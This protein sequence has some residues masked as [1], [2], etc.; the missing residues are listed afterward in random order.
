MT[1]SPE[2]D[3]PADS[4]VGSRTARG[5]TATF[6]AALALQ[7]AIGPFATDMYTPAFPQVTQDLATTS[8]LIGLTITTFFIG[9]GSGQVI[10]GGVSDQVGRR[11]PILAG[12]TVAVLG[13]L[14]C[15]IAPNIWVLLA[16]RFLQGFGGGAAAAVGRAILTDVARGN[17]LARTMSLLQAIGGLAPMLAPVL[18]AL[19]IEHFPWRVVFWTLAGGSALMVVSA[20][21]WTWESLPA[22]QRGQR[23]GLVEFVS[24]LGHVLRERT[25]VSLMFTSAFSFFCL[26]AYISNSSY[27]FQE[28]LGL[29]ARAYSFIFA[30][31]ALLS[32]LGA[33]VNIRLVGR[34]QPRTL[35]L[36]GLTVSMAAVVL[37]VVSV[38]A[39][40]TPLIAVAVGFALLMAAQSFVFGNA[41]ALALGS[42]R[43]WAGTASAIQGLVQAL[44]A[45]VSSPL[46]T[47]GGADPAPMTWVMVAGICLACVAFAFLPR[48][49][50]PSGS[51]LP[52][53]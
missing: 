43:E 26:F 42:V 3:A 28:T 51:R 29:S 20:W 17:T 40:G 13:S 10:G 35:I 5:V 52:T 24:G 8:A 25:F 49:S 14:V 38:F 37:L 15:A 45:A 27:V 39:L 30:G 46:A 19:I 41:A 18:G 44:A 23:G 6:L 32:T 31:N 48:Q 9:F 16:G 7:N 21:M 36:A 50:S 33:L 53:D 11:W 2:H 4:Q 34:F 1:H 22:E 12:G 47:A